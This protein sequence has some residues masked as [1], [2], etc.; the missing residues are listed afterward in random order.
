M[1]QRQSSKQ[2][3]QEKILF[4]S[5]AIMRPDIF[6]Q[7]SKYIQQGG[8]IETISKV[9]MERYRGIPNMIYIVTQVLKDVAPQLPDSQNLDPEEIIKQQVRN[10]MLKIFKT[11]FQF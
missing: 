11:L 9:L 6:E 8:Q 10:A 5:D 2:I 4:E 7:L 3:E 1:I